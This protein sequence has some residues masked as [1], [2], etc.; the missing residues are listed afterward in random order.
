[1][2]MF[3]CKYLLI[4]GPTNHNTIYTDEHIKIKNKIAFS[5]GYGVHILSIV[6]KVMSICCSRMCFVDI[7]ITY[8]NVFVATCITSTTTKA[9]SPEI[10]LI[11]FC[12]LFAY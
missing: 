3:N 7:I 12:I 9:K 5:C 6:F 8:H 4:I 1:M 10:T 11:H 2:F